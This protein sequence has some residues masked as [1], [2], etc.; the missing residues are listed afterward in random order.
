MTVSVQVSLRVVGPGE[1]MVSTCLSVL[2]VVSYRMTV[3]DCVNLTLPTRS[4]A[5]P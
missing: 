5:S 4:L 1:G 3:C 2:L